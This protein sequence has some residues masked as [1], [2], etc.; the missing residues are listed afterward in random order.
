MCENCVFLSIYSR[1]GVP[2]FW[3]ARHSVCLDTNSSL[4]Q[5]FLL[6]HYILVD[7]YSSLKFLFF[8]Y[9]C[10][11]VGY[12]QFTWP[13]MNT[14]EKHCYS[15]PHLQVNHPSGLSSCNID[16]CDMPDIYTH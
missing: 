10:S 13:N 7:L 4:F 12:P 15:F 3:A 5:Y 2:D 9:Y 14:L 6:V 16:I 11:Y 8:S 1:C